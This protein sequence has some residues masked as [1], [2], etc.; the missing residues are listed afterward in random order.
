[1]T[2]EELYEKIDIGE[3][4][5]IEFKSVLRVDFQS[6]LGRQY[7][8]LLILPVDTLFWVW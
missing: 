4:A 5:D 6:L 7:L 2:L 1:M 8:L 3:N